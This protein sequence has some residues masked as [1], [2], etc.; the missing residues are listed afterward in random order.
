[1]MLEGKNALI[2]G[3]KQGIGKAIAIQLASQGCNIGLNDI[4]RD[5]YAEHTL[6]LLREYGVKVSWY[7]ADISSKKQTDKMIKSFSDKHN[8]IDILVNNA[9]SSIKKP[10]L[11]I[12]EDDWE[13][14][15]GNA[16]KGYLF[17]S[18][19]AAKEMIKKG[20]GGR[21]VSISSV[22]SFVAAKDNTV[23]GICKA[24]INRMTMSLSLIHI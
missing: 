2:T 11:E 10:F 7:K 15:V 21:I 16:L 5:S 20:I 9:V 6:K 8:G 3:S 23:Y 1:M 4:V 14:E 19:A 13:F 24:G 22:H 12:K 17:C 18:Q